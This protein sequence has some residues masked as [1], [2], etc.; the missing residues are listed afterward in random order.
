MDYTLKKKNWCE[1]L[2][3]KIA[4]MKYKEKKKWTERQDRTKKITFKMEN[5]VWKILTNK[6]VQIHFQEICIVRYVK[7]KFLRQK[8]NAIRWKFR[9]K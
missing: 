7:K 2:T 8:E 9:S 3:I 1:A 4:Q 6:A 5:S